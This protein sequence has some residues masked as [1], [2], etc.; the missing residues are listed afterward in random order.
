MRASLCS[1][2]FSLTLA[3]RYGYDLYRYSFDGI[4]LPTNGSK[5]LTFASSE[6]S[7]VRL[8]LEQLIVAHKR[9]ELLAVPIMRTL[10]ERKWKW[11]AR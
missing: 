2:P 9:K 8:T 3:C 4:V 11:F 5:A 7:G 1:E 6:R 10:L